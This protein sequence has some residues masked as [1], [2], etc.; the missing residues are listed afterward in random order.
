VLPD[1]QEADRLDAELRSIVQE[2]DGAP[3]PT[4]PMVTPPVSATP[5]STVI[6]RRRRR[7]NQAYTVD[8]EVAITTIPE[9]PTFSEVIQNMLVG[10]PAV[11]DSESEVSRQPSPSPSMVELPDEDPSI[12]TAP[13]RTTPLNL[14][15]TSSLLAPSDPTKF[16]E[17]NFKMAPSQYQIST[18]R[19]LVSPTRNKSPL[20][21]SNDRRPMSD[22]K[23]REYITQGRLRMESI[24]ALLEQVDSAQKNFIADAKKIRFK[25]YGIT[26]AYLFKNLGKPLEETKT[27]APPNLSVQAAIRIQRWYRRIHANESSVMAAPVDLA[28]L[29]Q[30]EASD[31][32]ARLR[33]R[34]EKRK[35]EDGVV[36]KKLG[37][38]A[39]VASDPSPLLPEPATATEWMRNILGP[40]REVL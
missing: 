1:L 3:I 39:I 21:D 35:Q 33:E 25:S 20:K 40:L 34:R 11:T 24:L 12:G 36:E 26:G 4:P 27:I 18:P 30:M 5:V 19:N 7:N 10:Q 31:R 15:P 32:R 28:S 6:T 37:L 23:F 38:P 14:P 29:G 22:D 13:V 17:T 9:P 8:P 2:L 16:D